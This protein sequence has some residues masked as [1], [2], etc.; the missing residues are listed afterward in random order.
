MHARSS[1][2]AVCNAAEGSAVVLHKAVRIAINEPLKLLATHLL[3][4]AERAGNE[5]RNRLLYSLGT[6]SVRR[7]S[8]ETGWKST[9]CQIEPLASWLSPVYPD[10]P[11]VSRLI[12][13]VNLCHETNMHQRVLNESQK[14]F[15]DS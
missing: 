13:S 7:T 9:I 8:R 12:W 1:A 11:T 14:V 2:G 3:G 4:P 6:P 10:D 15:L 5:L